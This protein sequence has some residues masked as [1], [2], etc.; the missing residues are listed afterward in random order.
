VEKINICQHV[1][2]I[3]TVLESLA[4]IAG[5]NMPCSMGWVRWAIS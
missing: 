5:F 1:N 2:N 3:C 4:C